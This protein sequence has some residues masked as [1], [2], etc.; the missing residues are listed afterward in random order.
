MNAWNTRYKK[1]HNNQVPSY[2][3]V[4]DLYKADDQEVLG[5]VNKKNFSSISY[6]N[7]ELQMLYTFLG[8]K[9]F[10]T[11]VPDGKNMT[12]D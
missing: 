3:A 10:T 9:I 1:A 7:K 4:H 6:K 12:V 2:Q 5:L 8:K 11:N